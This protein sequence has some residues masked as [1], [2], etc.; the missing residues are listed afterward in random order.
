MKF[1]VLL[2]SLIKVMLFVEMELFK[3]INLEL[4][5]NKKLII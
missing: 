2:E 1:K 4:I 5:D 3:P